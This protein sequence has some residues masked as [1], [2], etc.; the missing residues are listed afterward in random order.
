[1]MLDLW[2]RLHSIFDTP[3]EGHPEIEIAKLT[4][5]A[6]VSIINYLLTNSKNVETSFTMRQP[7]Q[8]V[9]ITSPTVITKFVASG[10]VIGEFWCSITLDE[11]A[12]P[13]MAVFIDGPDYLAL[14]YRMGPGWDPIA[15]IGLFEFLRMVK[16][17]EPNARIGLSPEFFAHSWCDDFARTLKDYLNETA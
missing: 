7:F 2:E 6:L 14:E 1:M 4:P 16:L 11:Y 8:Q 12:L 5:T 13:D 3:H 9:V 10:A 17:I 15:L